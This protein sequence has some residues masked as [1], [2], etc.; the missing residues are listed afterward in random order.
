MFKADGAHAVP[1]LICLPQ[2]G[3]MENIKKKK[4]KLKIDVFSLITVIIIAVAI[5]LMVVGMSINW[6]KSVNYYDIGSDNR[7]I[8]Y[9][10]FNILV[11]A[12]RGIPAEVGSAVGQLGAYG[13]L[14]LVLAAAEIVFIILC[15][16][17]KLKLYKIIL[18]VLS[19]LCV[20]F[21][22][23]VIIATNSFCDVASYNY[24][25][26]SAFGNYGSYSD[27]AG[28]WLAAVSGMVSGITG[29]FVSANI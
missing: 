13:F 4:N 21:S 16:K 3:Y 1:L 6:A 22:V 8:S 11:R 24:G 18:A 29:A 17:F 2:E 27:E 20:V 28:M 9:S 25:V 23:L 12:G 15:D 26:V 19:V 10:F 5:V 7:I 14:A